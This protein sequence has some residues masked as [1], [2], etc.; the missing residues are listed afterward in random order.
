MTTTPDTG[1][2]GLTLTPDLPR[3]AQIEPVGRC[4]LACKMCTVNDR[5]DEVAQLSLARFAALLDQLP[6]L[7]ELHLW[8]WEQLYVTA[9]GELLPCCMVAI[10]DRATFGKIFEAEGGLLARWHG[11]A[12]RS[13]RGS[14]AGSVA[15]TVCRSRALYHGTF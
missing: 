11:E 9:A 12:A 2:A 10:A 14:L 6:G 5:G 8:P 3:F 1:A 13:F 4:N 15:P 7:Q